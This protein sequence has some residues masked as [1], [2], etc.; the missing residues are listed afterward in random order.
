MVVTEYA[1]MS[2]SRHARP[3]MNISHNLSLVLDRINQA[4]STAHRNPRSVQLLAVSKTQPA[5]AVRAAIE[6]GQQHFG[7]NYLQDALSKIPHFP[8]ATWHFIGA[9]QS[10]KTRDIAKHFDYVHSVSSL[11]VIQRLNAQRDEKQGPLNIFL[12]MNVAQEASKSGASQ[13]EIEELAAAAL[14]SPRLNL[15][16]LMAI[17]P[18]GLTPEE[19]G[20]YYRKLTGLQG[21]LAQRFGQAL[22]EC[23]F[24]M[25]QDLEIAIASGSTWVRVG[26]AIFGPRAGT[27]ANN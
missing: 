25:S 18:A 4:E 23:S 22:G 1:T 26:T 10:N 17:P 14:E 7:E 12:Q 5:S 13:R 24:G 20:A 11:K 3:F 21:R 15:L 16:G 8:E 6:A 27:I 9:I 2:A 19:L